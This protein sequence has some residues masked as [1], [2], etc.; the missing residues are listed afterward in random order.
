MLLTATAMIAF[1]ANSVLC[2]LALFTY[3]IC[4]SFAYLTLAVGTGALV[5]F[6]AVQL[7]MFTVALRAGESFPAL[8]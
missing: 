7:T 2:R 8:S 5:A 4:F 1:A 3:M 6:G